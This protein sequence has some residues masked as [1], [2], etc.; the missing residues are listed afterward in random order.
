MLPENIQEAKADV[1]NEFIRVRQE[2]EINQ[3]NLFTSER[4]IGEQRAKVPDEDARTEESEA[5]AN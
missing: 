2:F 3:E 1:M 4:R 5:G